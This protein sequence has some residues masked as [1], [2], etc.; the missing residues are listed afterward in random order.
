MK[1]IEADLALRK[2]V[3]GIAPAAHPHDELHENPR[4][5]PGRQLDRRPRLRCPHASPRF[6]GRRVDGLRDRP[7]DNGHT[8][9]EVPGPRASP[10]RRLPRSPATRPAGSRRSR[11]LAGRSPSPRPGSSASCR[12][13][14]G[15]RCSAGTTIR[16]SGLGYTLA[17]T[18]IN[19]CDFS[20]GSWALDPV[21][22]D[23]ALAHFSL[24]P[25]RKWVLPLIH[26][27]QSIAGA[28]NF[29]LLA[30]PWSPPSWMK[31]NGRMTFGGSLRPEY[32]Q[33]WADYMVRFIR[34]WTARSTSPS[35]P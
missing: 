6:S 5:N 22:G 26:D 16:R 28:P 7:V 19:S 18:H 34:R 10:R 12:P 17:R 31:T 11:A 25:M 3:N 29:H 14:V 15:P 4:T 13:S 32:R 2:A 9:S 30:S 23:T 20:L 33:A 21:A 8:L 35:G 27:V 1:E 24:D